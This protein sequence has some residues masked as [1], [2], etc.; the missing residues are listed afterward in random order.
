MRISI[1]IRITLL[2]KSAT[3]RVVFDSQRPGSGVRVLRPR[4]EL[5]HTGALALRGA[6]MYGYSILRARQAYTRRAS[7]VMHAHRGV[8][9]ATL[10]A[11][12]LPF[13]RA[14]D[15]YSHHTAVRNLISARDA[16]MRT[17][18]SVLHTIHKSNKSPLQRVCKKCIKNTRRLHVAVCAGVV[19]CTSGLTTSIEQR[20]K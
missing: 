11:G 1:F 9:V 3:L 8:A 10:F 18:V 17:F 5:R 12:H 6:K 16:L 15:D 4:R 7:E 19:A 2:P 13:E 14:E 20:P